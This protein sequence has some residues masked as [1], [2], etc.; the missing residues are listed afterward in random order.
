MYE[1]YRHSYRAIS[2]ENSKRIVDQS[3]ERRPRFLLATIVGIAESLEQRI[4]KSLR[5]APNNGVKGGNGIESRHLILFNWFGIEELRKRLNRAHR[6]YSEKRINQFFPY[7]FEPK[8]FQSSTALYRL[9]YIKRQVVSGGLSPEF[10]N[11]CLKNQVVSADGKTGTPAY[12][13]EPSWN[14]FGLDSQESIV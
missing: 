1:C 14:W 10:W 6:T 9:Y 3:L 11:W 5:K 2:D 12:R 4:C 7:P 13:E 8:K